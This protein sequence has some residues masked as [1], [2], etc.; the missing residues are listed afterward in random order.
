MIERNALPA[1]DSLHRYVASDR[2]PVKKEIIIYH[3][4]PAE[5]AAVQVFSGWIMDIEET[6][7]DLG[8][9]EGGGIIAGP[10]RKC[11]KTL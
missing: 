7:V 1:T 4:E 2:T 11:G 8:Q 5:E 6:R 9:N 10:G 3:P